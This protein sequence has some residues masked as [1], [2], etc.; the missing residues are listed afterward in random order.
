MMSFEIL[1]KGGVGVGGS[2]AG[3]LGR[4]LKRLSQLVDSSLSE[5]RLEAGA[6]AP[7]RVTMR[8]L[9]E[10][11]E[12]EAA[13]DASARNMSPRRDPGRRR[14]RR[15]V[16]LQLLF[17]ALA[18]LLQNAFKFNRPGGRVTLRTSVTADRVLIDVEDECGGLGPGSTERLFRA[19]AQ[20]GTDR[21]G[22]GLGLSIARK[23]VEASRGQLRVVDCPGSG[24]CFTHRPAPG[25]S[26]G[27][28]P[29]PSTAGRKF[30]PDWS[31]RGRPY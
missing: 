15:D 30:V 12:V 10:Q 27:G 26:E 29:R 22:V 16:D 20:D 9:L 13:M 17:A 18:N 31:G 3:I 7:R 2:T 19:F 4:S 5:V 14:G 25:V 11:V 6:Q 21:S 8:Q 23:S 1:Q 24:C 28:E